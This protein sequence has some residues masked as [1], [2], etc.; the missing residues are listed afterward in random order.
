MLHSIN[1]GV[2]RI[3]FIVFLCLWGPFMGKGLPA[4]VNKGVVG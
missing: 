3:V 2:G 4:S 1:K